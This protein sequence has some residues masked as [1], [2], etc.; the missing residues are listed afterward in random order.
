MELS[1]IME[2]LSLPKLNKLLSFLTEKEI[3]GAFEFMSPDTQRLMAFHLDN[4]RL[5][6]V[7]THMSPDEAADFLAVLDESRIGKILNSLDQ[8]TSRNLQRLMIHSPRYLL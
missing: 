3:A 2:G 5:A 8:E 4:Q 7:I 1:E 6:E